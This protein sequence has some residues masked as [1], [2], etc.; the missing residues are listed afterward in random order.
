MQA[1]KISDKHTL[2]INRA[3]ALV[4]ICGLFVLTRSLVWASGV[5]P[6]DHVI[7]LMQYLEV[8]LLQNDLAA[9]LL[10]LHSQPPL[11]NGIIG[12]LL[13]ASAGTPEVFIVLYMVVSLTIS[14]LIALM[15]FYTVDNIASSSRAALLC[16]SF[17]IVFMSSVFYENV[18]HYFLFTAFLSTAMCFSAAI[19][20]QAKNVTR[21]QIAVVLY[22]TSLLLLSLTWSL[23]H[24]IFVMMGG[25]TICM[26]SYWRRRC[27]DGGVRF[28][29]ILFGTIVSTVLAFVVPVK[30]AVIFNTFASSSWSG[31]NLASAVPIKGD[32]F[33]W[34]MCDWKA[35]PERYVGKADPS[36]KH[37][38]VVELKKF[39]SIE[40]GSFGSTNFNHSSFIERSKVCMAESLRAIKQHPLE[41]VKWVL[42]RMIWS[43][44]RISDE[45]FLQPKEWKGIEKYISVKNWIYIR[46][47]QHEG[48]SVYLVPLL[49]LIMLYPAIFL[50]VIK[51]KRLPAGALEVCIIAA[52]I[53]TWV[54]TVA[55]AASDVEQQRMRFTIEPL[56]AIIAALGVCGF[57][58]ATRIKREY[59]EPAEASAQKAAVSADRR[60]CV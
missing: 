24:P 1:E 53:I 23:F 20:F 27:V 52:V 51:R 26:L 32:D 14:L 21:G 34:E 39:S 10:Y 57:L 50:M 58:G 60:R 43:N 7:L 22:F 25:I 54:M 9:S 11:W 33:D 29:E 36:I 30:N 40:L 46:V 55:H 4:F 41:Y 44:Q 8:T 3:A 56:Y 48:Y 42:R 5:R 15:L 12:L 31:M 38:A 37:P 45:Y 19:L 59:K 49:A 16:A 35:D 47:G 17:Y 13:K 6:D 18:V 2:R 28:R